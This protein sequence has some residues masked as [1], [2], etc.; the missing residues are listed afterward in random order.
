MYMENNIPNVKVLDYYSDWCYE[1]NAC[2][3]CKDEKN[4]MNCLNRPPLD[5][6]DE[7][8]NYFHYNLANDKDTFNR[9]DYICNHLC[10]FVDEHLDNEGYTEN[11]KRFFDAK[12]FV[13]A[14]IDEDEYEVFI[15]ENN[16]YKL[17]GSLEINEDSCSIY[18]N[19]NCVYSK[20]TGNKE[21]EYSAQSDYCD[22]YIIKKID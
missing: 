20:K 7:F 14:L 18:M 16:K 9:D 15:K 11:Q 8:L 10:D 1:T 5:G 17:I 12:A 21:R 6:L 13:S 19:Y 3:A 22:I 2:D 4:G